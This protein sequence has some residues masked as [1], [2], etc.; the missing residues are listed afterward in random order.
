MFKLGGILPFGVAIALINLNY[1]LK[2]PWYLISIFV[3]GSSAEF[4]N[5]SKV[6]K[7]REILLFLCQGSKLPPMQLVKKVLITGIHCT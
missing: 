4:S 5:F 1:M 6:I 7:P 2:V 3:F